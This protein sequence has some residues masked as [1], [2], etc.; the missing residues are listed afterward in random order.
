MQLCGSARPE[1]VKRFSELSDEVME[2][3][4]EELHK[5][6]ALTIVAMV[7]N[8]NGLLQTLKGGPK[9]PSCY[10]FG[11]DGS[12][13]AYGSAC[14]FLGAITGAWIGFE[15]C[16]VFCMVGGAIVGGIIGALS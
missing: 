15:M 1:T 6:L 3:E 8:G 12:G 7:Y 5:E 2:S 10:V 14:V 4:L 9:E 11:P 16:G 13:V